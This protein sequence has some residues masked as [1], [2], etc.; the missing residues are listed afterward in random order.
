VTLSPGA[1]SITIVAKDGSVAQNA[2]TRTITIYYVAPDSTPPTL[3]ITSHAN[4]Q[5]VSTSTVTLGGTAS[6]SG[7]G[8]N[9]VASVTV[10]GAR[11]NNDTASGAGVANWSKAVSL[12][13]G[14]NAFT[15]V[16]KDNSANQNATT[17]TISLNYVPPDTAAP[18]LSI[19]SHSD[20]QK[21]VS[22]PVTLSGTASD[23][24][25]VTMAS[26]G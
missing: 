9:G 5:T 11:A 7:R 25:A 2:T 12:V 17:Q 6:D 20:G 13:P 22:Q 24:G 3:S 19:T 18:A 23:G 8:S 21:V 26:P 16:A 15:V 4:G 14:A 1:N 10:N